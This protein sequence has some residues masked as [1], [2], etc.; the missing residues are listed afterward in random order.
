L[1]G[2]ECETMLSRPVRCSRTGLTHTVILLI[3]AV[4]LLVLA[5]C[6]DDCSCPEQTEFSITGRVRLTGTIRDESGMTLGDE[7]LDIAS[8]VKVFLSTRGVAIDEAVTV[9]GQYRFRGLLPGDY[10]IF[11]QA[12]PLHAFDLQGFVKI[13]D[14]DVVVQDTLDLRPGAGLTAYP[15]PF[16]AAFGNVSLM[17][18]IDMPTYVTLSIYDLGNRCIKTIVAGEGR[19]GP[20]IDIWSGTDEIGEIVPAGPYWAVLQAKDLRMWD[21]IF[22]Y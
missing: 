3:A 12:G 15:S 16:C 6:C 2:K 11:A 8:G 22:V 18:W 13:K 14:R 21:L 17:Y 10:Q 4:F 9:K 7:T 5:G 20:N 1:R 19:N